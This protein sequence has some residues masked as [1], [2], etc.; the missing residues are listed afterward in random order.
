[1]FLIVFGVN[2]RPLLISYYYG[3]LRVSLISASAEVQRS[4]DKNLRVN[5]YH[6]VVSD[7]V[8]VISKRVHSFFVQVPDLGIFLI[9]PLAVNYNFDLNAAFASFYESLRDWR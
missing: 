7:C 9:S 1:M 3:I 4:R 5:D 6:L 8:V 2:L